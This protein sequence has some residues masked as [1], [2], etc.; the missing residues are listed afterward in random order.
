MG[1]KKGDVVKTAFDTY[2]IERRRGA[3]GS[4]EVY[5]VSDADGVAYA[6]KFLDSERA[7]TTKL[8]RFKNEIHFCTKNTHPNI[9]Q[10][11]ASGITASGTTFYVMP[12]YS[13]TLR[14]L[15]S[16][17]IARPAVLPY[18]GQILDGVEAAHLRGVWH[19]DVKPENI[20]F[21][22][23]IDTLIVAD[24]GIAH[25]EE[26][27][28]LTAVETRNNERLANFLY[29]AP[30]QRN[31]N[32]RVDGKADIYAL[33]LILNEMF[34]GAV[35]QGTSFRKVSE[36]AHDY[37]YVDELVDLMLRQDP[38]ARPSVEIVKR[39]LIARGNEFLSVQRLNSLKSQVIPETEVD[40]PIIRTPIEIADADYQDGHLVFTLTAAPPPNWIAAFQNPRKSREFYPGAGPENF[41]FRGRAATVPLGPG[42]SAPR[43][44]EYTKSYVKLADEQYT[45]TKVWEHRHRLAQEH[46]RYR[47]KIE[48]EERRQK[49]LREIKG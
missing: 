48:E 32:Q 14:E 38:D 39:E 28:L 36:V 24:F 30:E 4:G 13:G 3:G 46:E 35:P 44:T 33:G 41:I 21:S 11:I 25:F 7:S 1:Y 9:I 17:G 20:L 10:I 40:D 43:L 34:S 42:M 6:A 23:E 18:F 15:I 49:I 31:R 27:D 29:S 2:T 22:A 12:L 47:K 37:G 16:K 8:K 45:E 5:E 19:R 26:D